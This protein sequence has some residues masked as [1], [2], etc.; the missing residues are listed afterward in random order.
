MVENQ[1]LERK[2]A[3]LVGVNI[4]ADAQFDVS[5]QELAGLAEACGYEPADRITQRLSQP[6]NATYIGPGKVQEVKEALYLCDAESVLVLNALSPA[7]LANLTKELEAEVLDKT[8]LILNI[9]G[10]RARSA[11]AKMQVEYARLQYMLPRLVGLR[12]NLS[13]Q[14]GTGGSMSNKG[15]GEKQIELDRRHIEKRMA[16]LRRGL[17]AVESDRET[18]RKRRRSAGIPLVSL[19][20]YTNAGKSTLLN[21]MLDTYCPDE[22]KRVMEKDMLFATLDTTVRK[23][24]LG[25]GRDFLLS[26]T[27]GF[28]HDLPHDLVKAFRSTLEEARLSDLLLQVV[29]CSDPHYERQIAVTE[30]TLRELGAGHIPMIYVMNKADKALSAEQETDRTD[31]A[32]NA[33]RETGTAAAGTELHEGGWERPLP[34]VTGNRIYLSA[35][36]GAGIEELTELITEQLFGKRICC[37]FLIPYSDAS[38]EH[39]LRAASEVLG[40]EY[41]EDGIYM[42]CRLEKEKLSAFQPYALAE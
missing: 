38:A 19:V 14:G 18:M 7:Q 13:R 40:T 15:S 8:G 32:E 26:D 22:E 33:S 35:K 27:V 37:S 36:T 11:E 20:G 5:M 29:D 12:Q 3:V 41:R 42:R 24:G 34:Y 9:F 31:G 1:V 6:E 39:R 10:E 17:A 21:Q 4:G 2:R 23:I 30:Q 28:I 25:N 16:E